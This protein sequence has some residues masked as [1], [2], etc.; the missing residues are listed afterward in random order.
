MNS[1]KD[2][3]LTIIVPVY[4][5]EENINKLEK[6]LSEYVC[7]SSV[8]TCILFVDDGSKDQSK[9]LIQEVCQRNRHL[10]YI[11]FARN[12]GLSAAIKAGI[13]IA[14]S[15]FVGYIDADLQTAPKDFELLLPYRNEY[16]MV[17]G[18]RTGRKDSL[19]KKLSSK[20]AN[21]FRRMM[22]NDGIEDTGCPLKII[23]TEYAKRIPMFTGMHRFLPALLQ[24]QHGR[25]KQV[26]VRHFERTAG[27]SKFHLWN[28]LVS[29]FMDCFAF[30]WMKKRYIN[31]TIEKEGIN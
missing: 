25:V 26:P 13:D 3:E 30:R 5:E 21:S 12:C 19:G 4:N 27:Q 23:H 20:I 9:T 17:M 29:P 16:E 14:Q 24:L 7:S 22:T 18:I 31:Y 11:S 1:T 2:Y 8:K 28:R 15:S 10:F 6:E